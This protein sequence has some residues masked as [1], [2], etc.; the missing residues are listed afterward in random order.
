MV[1]QELL[2][3]YESPVLMNNMKFKTSYMLY[4]INIAINTS[5]T[6]VK[7]ANILGDIFV[8]CKWKLSLI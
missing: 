3:T 1:L 6:D 8:I 7:N 4:L 2:Y 5:P